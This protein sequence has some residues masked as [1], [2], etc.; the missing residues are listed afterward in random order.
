MTPN[1]RNNGSG[2]VPFLKKLSQDIILKRVYTLR[3]NPNGQINKNRTDEFLCPY[4]RISLTRRPNQTA[5]ND[6]AAE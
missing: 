4:G 3:P 1:S 2:R 5:E 6:H